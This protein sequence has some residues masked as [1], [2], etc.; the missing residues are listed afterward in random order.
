MYGEV[1]VAFVSLRKDSHRPVEPIHQHLEKRLARYKLP[2][3]I[4]TVDT[5]PKNPVGKIDKLALRRCL[6]TTAGE[7]GEVPMSQ[8]LAL[9]KSH[10][11]PMA[12][13]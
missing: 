11:E 1:P 3:E 2:H 6:A 10:S 8:S 13:G 12:K 9:I 7:P 4:I 5:I